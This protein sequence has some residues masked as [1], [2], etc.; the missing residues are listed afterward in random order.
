[1]NSDFEATADPFSLFAE[2]LGEAEAAEPSDPN[3]MALA[4]VDSDGT[5]NV[6]MVLL[7]SFD[8]RGFVFFTNADS[9]KGAELAVR[10]RAA[11]CLHWKSLGRQVRI[12]GA[13][14]PATAEEADT[15]FATRARQSRIGAWASRQSHPLE[16][17][18]ALVAAAA[19]FAEQ[20]GDGDIPRPD[21]WRGYRV[22]PVEIEFWK[23]GEFRLHDR[24]RFTRK[25][26]GWERTRLYP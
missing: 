12:R 26:G 7:K 2:W 21:Y 6:R 8:E 9:T 13:V 18:A 14:E 19:K 25:T 3:A 15:Y 22:I 16:S 23:N 4:T 24:I 10:P 17:R 20:F 1:M 11:L 5:P